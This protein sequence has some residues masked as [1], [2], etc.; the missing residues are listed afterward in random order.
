MASKYFFIFF[1]KF[2]FGKTS[3]WVNWTFLKSQRCG[4]D[5]WR[6]N[7]SKFYYYF[8]W[9]RKRDNK[10]R[11]WKSVTCFWGQASFLWFHLCDY[12]VAAF[13]CDRRPHFPNQSDQLS[14]YLKT[15][16][17]CKFFLQMTMTMCHFRAFCGSGKSSIFGGEAKN[18]NPRMGASSIWVADW[19]FARVFRAAKTASPGD[20]IKHL[21]KKTA[22]PVAAIRTTNRRGMT[23]KNSR[24]RNS[25]HCQFWNQSFSAGRESRVLKSDSLRCLRAI[26]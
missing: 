19:R 17:N 1:L 12:K 16:P 21:F 7:I 14:S 5:F 20:V 11:F 25:D 15:W 8:L 24:T 2:F 3:F 10:T 18:R 23:T 6:H 13:R 4:C 22:A 26:F 9:R